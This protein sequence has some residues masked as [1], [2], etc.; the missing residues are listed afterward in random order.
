MYK[1]ATSRPPAPERQINTQSTCRPQSSSKLQTY[2]NIAASRNKLPLNQ[3]LRNPWTET[4][5]ILLLR[6]TCD[7]HIRQHGK[8]RN[9]FFPLDESGVC[10][11]NAHRT[12]RLTIDPAP[13]IST[14][15]E[16][17]K[18][19]KVT[20]TKHE[21][22]FRRRLHSRQKRDMTTLNQGA[23]GYPDPTHLRMSVIFADTGKRIDGVF[24]PPTRRSGA[25]HH[26]N[27]RE[28]ERDI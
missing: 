9:L 8:Q 17:R 18:C 1:R 25:N 3:L 19:S 26:P 4:S 21:R 23:R 20:E 28:R 2:A 14:L 10:E 7:L 22:F 12:C 11:N 13:R 16:F 5:Q 27:E 6:A 24:G 15:A